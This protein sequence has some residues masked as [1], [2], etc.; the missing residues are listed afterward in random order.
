MSL[1]EILFHI[2]YIFVIE[3]RHG[4]LIGISI[5]QNISDPMATPQCLIQTFSDIG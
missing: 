1:Y 2:L 3:L 4:I 5:E